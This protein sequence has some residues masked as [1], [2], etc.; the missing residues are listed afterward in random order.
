MFQSAHDNRI[1]AKHHQHHH[2][3]NHQNDFIPKT[4]NEKAKCVKR[5][6]KAHAEGYCHLFRLP[7]SKIAEIKRLYL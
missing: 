3:H 5:V 1:D 2:T 7:F 6:F 4:P